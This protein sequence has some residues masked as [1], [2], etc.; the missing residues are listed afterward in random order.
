MCLQSFF[1]LRR[2]ISVLQVWFV[3]GKSYHS[4]KSAKTMMVLSWE[5]AE[6]GKFRPCW[7]GPG[8]LAWLGPSLCKG[9]WWQWLGCSERERHLDS[10]RLFPRFL[11]LFT[12]VCNLSKGCTRCQYPNL[13]PD[14]FA[15]TLL[16]KTLLRKTITFAKL[17][18]KF[19]KHHCIYWMSFRVISFKQFLNQFCV[20]GYIRWCNS[21]A[22]PILWIRWISDWL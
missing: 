12:E 22:F 17:R 14:C 7:A 6:G 4:P 16:K 9:R 3:Q 21:N 20:L 8:S 13:V 18:F 1:S 10:H 2:R 19:L 5:M 15:I 11:W